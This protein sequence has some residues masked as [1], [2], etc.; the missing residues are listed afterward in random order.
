MRSSRGSSRRSRRTAPDRHLLAARSY[1]GR[2]RYRTPL[3]GWYLRRNESVAVGTD[4]EF[5]VLTVPPSLRAR[6][7]GVS[8]E[9]SDPRSSS[10]RE[11]GT[12]S[13]STSRTRWRALWPA[14]ADPRVSPAA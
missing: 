6:F 7:T 9:P 2:A 11:P 13:R 12:G 1:D 3:R 5:Y 10:A 4:G 8:P 14:T